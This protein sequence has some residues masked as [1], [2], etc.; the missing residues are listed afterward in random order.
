MCYISMTR[1]K[2]HDEINMHETNQSKVMNVCMHEHELQE[3]SSMDK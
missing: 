3:L 2:V 1:K